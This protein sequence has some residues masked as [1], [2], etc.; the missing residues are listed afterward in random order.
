MSKPR[1]TS[2]A[3]SRCAARLSIGAALVLFASV[4][5]ADFKAAAPAGV[6]LTGYWKLNASLSDDAEKLLQERL[7]EQRRE[8][9]R[10]MRK[11]ARTDPLGI[12]PVGEP[13]PPANPEA[14]KS[15]EPPRA[16][17][18]ARNRRLNELRRM[19]GMSDTLSVRQA[20]ARV[21]IQSQWESRSFDA[22]SQTQVSMPTGELA[23]SRVGWDGQWFVIER[24]TK[25]G[26]RVTEKYR[27]IAKTDQLESQIQWGGESPLAGIKVRR[28]YDRMLTPPPP[29]DPE[30]GP[31]R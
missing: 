1:G 2:G 8:Y 3:A 21:E 26:P 11:S 16:Q 14:G 30:S 5:L 10:W 28:I 9:E 19:L 22:G 27:L 13:M 17:P 24:R 18:R 23:D 31:V 7:D 25:R 12:P 15:G 29:P 20:A 6:D 4:G